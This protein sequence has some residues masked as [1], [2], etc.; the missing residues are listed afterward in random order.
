[1]QVNEIMSQNSACCTADTKL[2]DVA[3]MMVKHD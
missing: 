1:M 2:H 3:G